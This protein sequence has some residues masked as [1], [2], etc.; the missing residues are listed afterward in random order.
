[1]RV[2]KQDL[3]KIKKEYQRERTVVEDGAEAVFEEEPLKEEQVYFVMDRFGYAKTFDKATSQR[4]QENASRDYKYI[5]PCMNTDKIFYFY[6][7]RRYRSDQSA[8]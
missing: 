1:M 3:M 6:G 8:K 5:V 2:M 7:H 4:N